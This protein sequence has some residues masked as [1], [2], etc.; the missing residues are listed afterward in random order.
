MVDP[1]AILILAAVLLVKESGVPIPAPGDLLVLGAGVAAATA[2][3]IGLLV[4]IPILVAGF[5][6]G[7]IQFLIVRGGLRERLFRI[8]ARVG[9][10]RERLEALAARLGRQGTRGVAV[11]R[12][13]PGLRIGVIAASGIAALPFPT[14]LP[15]LVAG[16]TIFVGAHFMLGYAVGGPALKLVS[17]AGGILVAVAV[18]VVLAGVGALG[19][20]VLR[21]RRTGSSPSPERPAETSGSW[22]D[23]ACP[24]CLVLAAARIT[25]Y[26]DLS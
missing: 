21:R 24:A 6:G 23:A 3:P 17:D 14:F 12:T 19:W 1:L 20:S 8:L 4:L 22:A 11:A 16:N 2:G 5:V 25:P 10:S 7:S 18:F 9:V 26:P 15:G 13:V